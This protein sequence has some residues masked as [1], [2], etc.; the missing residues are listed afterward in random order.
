MQEPS[1]GKCNNCLW[2]SDSEN[3][4]Y[5]G[6]IFCSLFRGDLSRNYNCI[7]WISRKKPSKAELGSILENCL[8]QEEKKK[9]DNNI[10]WNIKWFFNLILTKWDFSQ[11][12]KVLKLIRVGSST[13]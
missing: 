6:Y 10:S 4:V 8:S 7:S 2:I 5:L 12:T 9:S 11:E 13:P 3:F 1:L